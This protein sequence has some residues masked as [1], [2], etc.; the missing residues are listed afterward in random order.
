M[1]NQ[2]FAPSTVWFAFISRY[3][4]SD[5]SKKGLENRDREIEF[6]NTPIGLFGSLHDIIKTMDSE[7]ERWR[8]KTSAIGDNWAKELVRKNSDRRY[9]RVL[10][11]GNQ[12]EVTFMDEEGNE[13]DEPNFLRSKEIT[14][15]EVWEVISGLGVDVYCFLE[16]RI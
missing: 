5:D 11:F 10:D 12:P 3:D 14:Q 1:I 9:R 2:P 16:V 15:K 8:A 7:N 6:H 13:T 4:L